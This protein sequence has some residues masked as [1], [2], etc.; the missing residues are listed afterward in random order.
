VGLLLLLGLILLLFQSA[1]RMMHRALLKDS[2]YVRAFFVSFV[3]G[4]IS[5]LI[6]SLN[7]SWLVT[8]S[9]VIS[10]LIIAGAI[11]GFST[12]NEAN[13]R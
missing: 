4:G 6:L 10:L 12:Q 13:E 9:G 2:P 8:S 3:G 1:R 11:I 7:T 5:L